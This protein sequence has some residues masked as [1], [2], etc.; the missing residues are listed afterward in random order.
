MKFG[1][2]R[3]ILGIIGLIVIIQVLTTIHFSSKHWPEEH[4]VIGNR[5]VDRAHGKTRA[6]VERVQVKVYLVS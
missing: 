5:H 2:V 6:H 4:P 1:I 3:F